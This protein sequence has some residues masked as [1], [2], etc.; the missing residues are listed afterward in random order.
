VSRVNSH[1]AV[2]RLGGPL[3]VAIEPMSVSVS[4]AKTLSRPLSGRNGMSRVDSH[5]AVEGL[6]GSL[7]VAGVEL[8]PLLV[9]SRSTGMRLADGV[10][11]GQLMSV[12]IVA[13]LQCGGE[14]DS[15][16]NSII[17]ISTPLT[18]ARV[19]LSP[20]L[21]RSGGTW[22][23]LADGVAGGQLMSVHIVAVLQGGGEGDSIA[24][25]RIGA[26]LADTVALG[27]VESG[28]SEE[29]RGGP[30]GKT[31]AAVVIG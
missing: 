11:R 15:V 5:S 1:S 2:E 30:G 8:S 7:A 4:K 12:H 21:E 6:S 31:G 27:S 17:S 10:A 14:G 24:N 25:G 28:S 9:R 22:V 23:R 20:L 16:A 29:P 19:E 26:P 18:I 3:A 13:V